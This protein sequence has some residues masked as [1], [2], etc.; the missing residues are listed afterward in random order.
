M[1]QTS[2]NF[3]TNLLYLKVFKDSSELALYRMHITFSPAVAISTA[4]D[5]IVS[6]TMADC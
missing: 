5:S 1:G 4:E 6:K 3:F 2:S